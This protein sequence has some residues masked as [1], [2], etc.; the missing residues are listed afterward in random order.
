VKAD[1]G[2]RGRSVTLNSREYRS[3]LKKLI[4]DRQKVYSWLNACWQLRKCT[5]VGRWP[6]LDGS[7]F[8]HNEGQIIL[9]EHLLLHSRYA[10]TV[11]TTFGDGCLEIGDRTFINYGVDIAATK[12]I[13]IG[14][15]CL[16]GTHV[17]ILDN[18]YHDVK[19]H[20]LF[21]PAR[22]VTIGNKTWIG[23]RVIILPGVTIGEGVT[24]GAGSVVTKN[25]PDYSVAVG[26][27]A[28]VVRKLDQDN[29]Q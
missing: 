9:G 7:I 6:R 2:W 21:P 23:N 22:P 24:I 29:E 18:D 19:A 20:K 16:I 15:D 17:S 5:K 26:N 3:Q 25:I 28:R 4:R 13:K 10:H 1:L 8:I 11:L 27:P 14:S 12:L